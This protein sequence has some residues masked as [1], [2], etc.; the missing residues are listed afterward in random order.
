[1]SAPITAHRPRPGDE[2]GFIVFGA[3]VLI[4]VVVV[5][6]VLLGKVVRYQYPDSYIDPRRTERRHLVSD[7]EIHD[8]GQVV[9]RLRRG[10]SVWV[11][12][13]DNGDVAVFDE[14]GKRVIGFV[15]GLALSPPRATSRTSTSP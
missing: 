6:A 3:L 13:L 8:A 4:V 9:R 7:A 2:R 12:Q 1:M 5:T 10:D 14:P 15:S 11:S